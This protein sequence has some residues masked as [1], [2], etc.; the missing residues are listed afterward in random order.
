MVVVERIAFRS[1]LT[2]SHQHSGSPVGTGLPM[3]SMCI[4]RRLLTQSA[5]TNLFTL[6]EIPR[7]NGRLGQRLGQHRTWRLPAPLFAALWW[8]DILLGQPPSPTVLLRDYGTCSFRRPGRKADQSRAF[9]LAL[10]LCEMLRQR[11][12]TTSSNACPRPP[13]PVTPSSSSGEPECHGWHV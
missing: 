2:R 5:L 3:T 10:N 12:P 9:E 6:L 8:T 11:Y 13:W 4:S 7:L 1:K